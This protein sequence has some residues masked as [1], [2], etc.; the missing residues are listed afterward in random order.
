MVVLFSCSSCCKKYTIT[1]TDTL[2]VPEPFIV[3]DTL[4]MINVKLETGKTIRVIDTLFYTRDTGR[5]N[6]V[7]RDSTVI[8]RG[9]CIPDTIRVKGINK[10]YVETKEVS[11]IPLY[12]YIIG[13]VLLLL[14]LIL[15][16]K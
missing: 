6:Y 13:A 10:H 5:I 7:F 1:G 15:A 16:I 9:K 4:P 12:V 11:E 8:I 2:V 3:S 14:I